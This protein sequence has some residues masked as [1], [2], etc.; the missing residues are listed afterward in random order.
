MRQVVQNYKT[1]ELR[2]E[3][4]PVPA[5]KKG[6][7]IVR[8]EFS[9]VSSGTESTAVRQAAMSMVG[10]A[11]A[12]PEDVKKVLQNIKKQGL[13]ATYKAVMNRLDSLTPLGYSI[14]G[15]VIEVGENVE[16]FRRG[17]RVAC[18]GAGYANHAEY[19]F[20]PKNLVVPVP[21]GVGMDEAA[22]M[23]VG[24]VA[25]QGFRQSKLTLGDTV[26]VLGLGLVGQL[27]LQIARAAGCRTVGIDL[28]EARVK[29]ALGA[30]ADGACGFD[31]MAAASIVEDLTGGAGADVV[32][33]AVGA[34]SNEPFELAVKLVRDRGRLVNIGKTKIDVPYLPFFKKDLELVFS[35]SYGPG[36][37][38]PVYE[39]KGID[40]P[41]GYV[42]WT[43]K[44][45]MAAFLGLVAKKEIDLASIV[46]NVVP[47]ERA[48]EAY[49][50]LRKGEGGLGTLF[51]YMVS[52]VLPEKVLRTVEVKPAREC[53]EIVIGCIGAGNYAKTKLLPFFKDNHAVRLK[54]VA[55]TSGTTAK[56]TA[57][58]FAFEKATTDC[59]CILGDPQV[60]TVI[61]ATPHDSHA[62][63]ICQALEADKAVFAEKPLAISREQLLRIRDTIDNTGNDRLQI[64]FNR[65][66]APLTLRIKEAFENVS[67]P[68]NIVIR[69]SAG[70]LEPGSWLSDSDQSGGRIVGECCHFVDLASFLVG[71]EPIE[72]QAFRMGATS[73]DVSM[74]L[75]YP[76]GSIA[77]IVYITAGSWSVPKEYIEVHG[78][79]QTGIIYDFKRAVIHGK[80]NKRFGNGSQDKG[81]K[82]EIEAFCNAV[83]S[84]GKMP[85]AI[86]SLLATT[87]A[88]FKVLESIANKSAETVG[89]CAGQRN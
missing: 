11:K 32:A 29:Q 50:A 51:K 71:S 64:G 56:N 39:E 30:G 7:V 74:M 65:R 16:E 46:Q 33:L 66:F 44:R 62:E 53:S 18:G 21:E 80:K 84:G 43:E 15:T 70:R 85:I 77:T 23:T 79:G 81:Q 5:L 49:D 82:A 34:E 89:E 6:G 26:V 59:Q 76:N 31:D 88:T 73:D 57:S 75:R 48:E 20:V 40:Y 61:I 68:L 17:Q 55:T 83:L 14:S 10:K 2:L 52:D 9:L 19:N 41:I 36:R 38:D 42:K 67:E 27:Y 22:C 12:R 69:V 45:N 1:G 13:V 28:N 58:R 78:A 87:E 25:M 63:L 86:G 24:A 60:N 72:V 54:T 37:Y 35:R 8:T 4:V 47:F 3:E